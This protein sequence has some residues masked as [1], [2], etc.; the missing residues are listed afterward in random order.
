MRV[1]VLR[2]TEGSQGIV[3]FR[4]ESGTASGRWM[5]ADPAG[6][7]Q[8]DVELEIPQEVTDWA[9][10]STNATSLSNAGGAD[11]LDTFVTCEIVQLDHGDD[12]VV[13]ARLGAD[14]LLIEIPHRRSELVAKKLITFRAPEIQLYPF[15]V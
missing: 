4:C 8:F 9:P 13:E 10:A 7:G 3:F 15:N 11:D 14:I 12:P 5:G 6:V 2:T 1:E